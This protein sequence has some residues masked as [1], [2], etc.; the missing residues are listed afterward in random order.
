MIVA[1]GDVSG[2]RPERIEGR[3][4]AVLQLLIHVGLDLVH[5]HVARPLDH[6][7]HAVAPG[8]L[9][10][11][12]EGAQLTELRLV[13]GVGDGA[14]TQAVAQREGHVI[15][16]HDLAD[17]F[18]V[19]VE[20]VLLVVRQAPLGH[21]RAAARDDAGD[22]FRGHGN[23]GQPHAG[24][25]GEIVHPLLGLFDQGVAE[26]LPGQVLGDAI[27]LL[28]SLVDRHGPDGHGRVTHDPV[29][30]IVDVAA[31]GEVHDGVGAAPLR[32]NKLVHLV[33]DVAEHR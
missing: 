8:H 12:A 24:V 22:A 23:E 30:D 26:H 29:A 33:G 11:L 3:L 17:V 5:G 25:D 4:V 20:E 16:A 15:G 13:V 10:Q 21:D 14:G 7:L 9:G 18:E 32:P 2:E 28:Q 1:G 31:G 19:V 6:G 27:D